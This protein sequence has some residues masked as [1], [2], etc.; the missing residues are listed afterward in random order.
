[1]NDAVAS[2]PENG[3]TYMIRELGSDRVLTLVDGELTLQLNDGTR[4]G[5]HWHCEENP[6]GWIGFRDAV[7]GSYLGHNNKGGYIARAKRMD[8]WE[9]FVLRPR[10]QGGYN[11]YVKHWHK[12]KPM[13]VTDGDGSTPSFREYWSPAT[14]QV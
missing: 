13:G 4:G 3:Q 10:S 7:S 6:D 12:L 11:L 8:S 9:C 14:G 5:W 2:V 1:M